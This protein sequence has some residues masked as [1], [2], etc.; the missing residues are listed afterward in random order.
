MSGGQPWATSANWQKQQ[1]KVTFIP[2]CSIS[3]TELLTTIAQTLNCSSGSE[4]VLQNW[5]THNVQWLEYLA[6]WCHKVYQ[7]KTYLSGLLRLH[8]RL[9]ESKWNRRAQ[10]NESVSP[11]CSYCDWQRQQNYHQFISV[12]PVHNRMSIRHEATTWRY[13]VL[14]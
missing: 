3:Q 14:G 12:P 6:K 9:D 4:P 11:L 10:I 1:H 8:L 7:D 5:A 2:W 13:L